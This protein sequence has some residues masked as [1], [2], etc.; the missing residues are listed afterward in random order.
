MKMPWKNEP[1]WVSVLLSL[2][3]T[4]LGA[5]ANYAFKILSGELFSWRTMILQLTVS[6]FSG[7]LMWLLM[8]HYDVADDFAGAVCG[9]AGWSGASLIKAL[10]KRILNKVN[11]EH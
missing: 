5:I 8:H 1:S 10:E 2:G 9:L 7:A 3:M 6:L 4:V 11:N